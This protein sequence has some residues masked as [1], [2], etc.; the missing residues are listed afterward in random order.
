MM[1]LSDGVITYTQSHCTEVGAILRK[2]SIQA[3]PNAVVGRREC[4]PASNEHGVKEDLIY[5]GRLVA[6]KKPRLLVE[7]F[8]L[9]R[10]R[11][12][13]NGNLMIVGEGPE[14]AALEDLVSEY[15]LKDCVFFYGQISDTAKLRQLYADALCSVSPGYAGLSV[16]QS[17]AF[18]VPML[19]ADSEP[20][21]PEIEACHPDFNCVYFKS[22]SEADLAD[23]IGDFQRCRQKWINLNGEISSWTAD[24]YTFEAMA[25]PFLRFARSAKT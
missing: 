15:N 1:R 14:R 7:G 22:D 3:A 16:I 24:N 25:Q 20:H 23:K 10:Q 21:S 18:G 2:K 19:V 9:A 6:A 13:F 12:Q 8:R 4:Y 5:V 17:F 11:L